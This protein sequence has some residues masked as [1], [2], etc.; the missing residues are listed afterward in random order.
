[1]IE[2]SSCNN[3][4]KLYLA[5]ISS[6]KTIRIDIKELITKDEINLISKMAKD[7]LS[8]LSML[9]TKDRTFNDLSNVD[10]LMLHIT[11]RAKELMD[12][13]GN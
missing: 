13:L 8:P 5:N 3:L 11:D 6:L 1:M 4:L 12:K 9:A 10:I 2:L 7:K